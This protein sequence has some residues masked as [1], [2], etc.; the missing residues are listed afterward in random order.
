MHVQSYP[1]TKVF[2]SQ[3]PQSHALNTC[4]L[5]YTRILFAGYSL[6][7]GDIIWG[8]YDSSHHILLYVCVGRRQRCM[9]CV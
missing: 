1:H 2:V 4:A 8:E 5:H 6:S 3:I 9:L 7:W